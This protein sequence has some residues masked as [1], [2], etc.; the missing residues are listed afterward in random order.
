ME[1][2]LFNHVLALLLA[3]CGVVGIPMP[4]AIPPQP[5]E[6]ALTR[7]VPADAIGF[8][9][10]NGT[11]TADPKSTN[12][13]ER[14]AAEPEVRAML[15]QLRNGVIGL[16]RSEEKDV[17]TQTVETLFSALEHPGC[18]FV[19]KFGP[20][21]VIEAGIVVRFGTE[22]T[23]ATHLLEALGELVGRRGGTPHEDTVVDGVTFHSM[24][25]D[26][27]HP[28][29]GWAEVDGW[30][31]LAMGSETPAQIIA[32]LRNRNQGIDGNADYA[33]LA[34][35]CQ[36][37]RPST[38]AFLDLS[39]LRAT[40]GNFGPVGPELDALLAAIGLQ[41]A[42]ALASQSGLEGNGF[43]Q[44]MRLLAPAHDGLL[45][46]FGGEPLNQDELL[47]IPLDAQVAA[48]VRVDAKK[49]EAALLRLVS[50]FAGQDIAPDYEREFVA[51]FPNHL[52]G[53]RWR[54]DVLDQL[55]EQITLWNS[56]SQGGL[57]FT[58][59]SAMLPLRDGKTF[60]KSMAKMM[61]TIRHD[62]PTKEQVRKNGERVRRNDTY[63][64]TMQHGAA[65]IDW[66]DIVE[67]DFFIAPSWSV[68]GDH[69]CAS[70]LPQA[71]KATI[72]AMPPNPDQSLARLPAINKRGNATA[73][74][75]WN[76][77][78][79]VAMGYP[80][81]LPVLKSAS[82]EW[83]REGIDFDIADLPQARSLLPHLGREVMLWEP[84]EQGYA[85][86]R[87]GT[88]PAFDPLALGLVG[89]MAGMFAEMF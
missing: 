87:N 58:G 23:A 77:K 64:E 3:V 37:A 44:R 20:K 2:S 25:T 52:G 30:V 40:L 60:A 10:W 1:M 32:G 28:F 46:A 66:L 17:A 81:L 85:Y 19:R 59:L 49:L 75:C 42:A 47:H 86:S 69:L 76:A 54:E 74:F 33:R 8:L 79:L 21:P 88:L 39:K 53:V 68:V 51:E 18:V 5:D 67:N 72:D 55:G 80:L 4:V 70:L 34:P 45:A 83:L 43:C 9:C 61:E 56:P 38:K 29:L 63:L 12:L 71:L 7:V 14:L 41:G 6:P 13:T 73:M 26:T 78:D 35:A 22:A 50:V 84:T 31:A 65:T 11:A 15:A 82:C 57:L 89:C 16:V 24:G 62:V 36:V 48:A 27:D